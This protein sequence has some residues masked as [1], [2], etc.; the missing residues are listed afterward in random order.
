MNM[1]VIPFIYDD[2]DDLFANT[3]LLVDDSLACVVIDPSKKYDGIINYIEKNSLHLKAVLLTHGHFDHMRGVDLLIEKY[4]VPLYISF[5]D[6]GCLKDT[7][8]NL[9]YYMSRESMVVASQA[10]TVSDKEVLHIL[11]EDIEVIHTPYHTEGCVCYYLKDSKILFSGDTLFRFSIGRDDFP[12]SSPKDKK[13]SLNKLM[14][15]PDDVKVYPG[16]GSFTK[17]GEERRNNP[18]V[19]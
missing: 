8:K 13:A 15:L 11:Q 10:I 6:E 1:K 5:Y 4:Q 2:Y 7:K 14:A 16:H 17:I 9:S 19:N 3:Y 12:N 18:F